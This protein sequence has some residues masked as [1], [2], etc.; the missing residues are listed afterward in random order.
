VNHC[1]AYLRH[2]STVSMASSVQ[3]VA[4]YRMGS[5]TGPYNT[6][7]EGS[8]PKLVPVM[9]T[10]EPPTVGIRSAPDTPVMTG[11]VKD[12]VR[13]ATLTNTSGPTTTRHTRFLP[14]PGPMEHRIR[15]EDWRL[16]VPLASEAPGAP[17][18]TV[19]RRNKVPAQGKKHAQFRCQHYPTPTPSFQSA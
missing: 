12:K 1:R 14:D 11:G 19:E 5:R 3:F 6:T 15:V 16:H 17:S 18:R 2:R 13:G 7:M 4:V 10:A 9:V 8:G